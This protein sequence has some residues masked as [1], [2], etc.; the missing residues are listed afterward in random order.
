MNVN[1]HWHSIIEVKFKDRNTAMDALSTK[2]D[3]AMKGF[4]TSA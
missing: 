1:G 3:K 4:A 2:V